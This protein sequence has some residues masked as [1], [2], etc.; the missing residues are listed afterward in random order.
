[1][2]NNG[3]VRISAK[4]D[5]AVRAMIELASLGDE[6]TKG[7]VIAERQ[8]IPLNFMENILGEL[9][10]HGIVESRRGAQGGY[11]L[12]RSPGDITVADIVRCVDGPLASI[13][14]ASPEQTEYPGKAAPLRDV[15][16]AL[17]MNVRSVLESTTLQ[18]LVDG[19]LPPE[20][21]EPVG[22][23]EAWVRR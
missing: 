15:W 2:R 9:K 17:R 11:W 12:S 16:I 13:R 21:T 19:D 23:P 7:E 6:P 4:S 22:D 8:G 1:M 5:Y 3:G 14:D 10:R 18:N 20:V